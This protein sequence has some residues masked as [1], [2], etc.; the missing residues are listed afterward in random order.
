[1]SYLRPALDVPHCHH[2]KWDGT[3]YPR[4]LRGE[5]IPHHAR[6]FAV[7][8]VWDALRS[9]RPYRRGWQE[10]EALKYVQDQVGKHF[11]PAVAKTFLDAKIFLHEEAG[12]PGRPRSGGLPGGT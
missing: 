12:P 8:D 10:A 2:E 3:G 1:I 11:E 4:G 5:E 9:D 6:I 7:A